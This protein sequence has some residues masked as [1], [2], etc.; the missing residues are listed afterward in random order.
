MVK[1]IKL[2]H[3]DYFSCEYF[4][5]D[6]LM[7]RSPHAKEHVFTLETPPC[8]IKIKIEPYKLQPIIRIDDIMVNYGLAEI[9]PWDHM[10][11]FNLHEDFFDRYFANIIESKR[12]YLDVDQNQ[13]HKKIG[14]EDLSDLVN[15]IEGKMR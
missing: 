3:T 7:D 1:Q 12:K 9:K 15:E 14:L 5:N 11:E 10:L 6:R 8:N 2:T 13:I 4:V